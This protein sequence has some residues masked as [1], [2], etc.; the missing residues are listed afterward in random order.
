MIDK[1]ALPHQIITP[2][3]SPRSPESP[4]LDKEIVITIDTKTRP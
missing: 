2:P 3:M 1:L 4:I